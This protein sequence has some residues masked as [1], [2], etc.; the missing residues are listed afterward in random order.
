MHQHLLADAGANIKPKGKHVTTVSGSKAVSPVLCFKKTTG[1]MR[2]CLDFCPR[3]L[4][5]QELLFSFPT[6]IDQLFDKL[7]GAIVSSGIDLH[8]AYN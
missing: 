1:D 3:M 8:R 5:S 2:M 4:N 7:H 6:R